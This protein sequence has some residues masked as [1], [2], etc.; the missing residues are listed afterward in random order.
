MI[1][2]ASEWVSGKPCNTPPDQFGLPPENV[3]S[4]LSIAPA[5]RRAKI[6]EGVIILDDG[7]EPQEDR[8]FL[9]SD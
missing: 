5:R 3:R 2:R 9:N 1:E 6:W 4:L 8:Q 7:Q